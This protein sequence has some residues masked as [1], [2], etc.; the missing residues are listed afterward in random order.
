MLVQLK[1]FPT[2]KP[3][4]SARTFNEA[5]FGTLDLGEPSYAN[6]ISVATSLIQK[7]RTAGSNKP[8]NTIRRTMG[9]RR[10]TATRSFLTSVDADDDP[11]VLEAKLFLAPPAKRTKA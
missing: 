2:Y 9:S 6:P 7:R 3:D 4:R 8:A 10:A 11:G 5:R 1:S